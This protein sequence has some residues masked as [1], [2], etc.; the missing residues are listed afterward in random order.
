[1]MSPR[2]YPRRPVKRG[3]NGAY[4][5]SAITVG[6]AGNKKSFAF[7][8]D[9]KHRLIFYVPYWNKNPSLCQD[10]DPDPL[11]CRIMP[12]QSSVF[13]RLFSRSRQK[14][15]KK[16]FPTRFASYPDRRLWQKKKA[17]QL[18]FS[19][20]P[21]QKRSIKKQNQEAMFRNETRSSGHSF[22][23][24]AQPESSYRRARSTVRRYPYAMTASASREAASNLLQRSTE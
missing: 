2:R 21:R 12:L 15:S 24:S 20:Y 1:M 16:F 22:F 18:A 8:S 6:P 7:C 9:M 23:S 17:R 5:S 11:L 4:R 14:I 19:P 13:D 3:L 10:C